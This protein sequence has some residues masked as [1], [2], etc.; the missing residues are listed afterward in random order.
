MR[1][2]EKGREREQLF[3]RSFSV[4][5]RAADSPLMKNKT[6]SFFSSLP[7]LLLLC[8][9]FSSLSSWS[10]SPSS[11]SLVHVALYSFL[12]LS[13]SGFYYHP[14]HT[15][16]SSTS[17]SLFASPSSLVVY[18]FFTTINTSDRDYSRIF[19]D[20]TLQYLSFLKNRTY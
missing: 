12:A 19:K 16:Y 7:L 15:Y 2:I 17:S 9:C 11:P 14:I 20:D 10:P 4:S 8:L 3:R 18:V 6:P 1:W 5:C 13:F